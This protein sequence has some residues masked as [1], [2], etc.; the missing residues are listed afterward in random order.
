MVNIDP[1]VANMD[2][3]INLLDHVNQLVFV[4]MV[5]VLAVALALVLVDGRTWPM[6]KP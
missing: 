1:T 5:L 2:D 3:I 4:L 6:P